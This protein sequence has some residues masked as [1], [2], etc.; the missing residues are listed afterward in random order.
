MVRLISQLPDLDIG[1][2]VV[3]KWS[4]LPVL[5][6]QWNEGVLN[7]GADVPLTKRVNGIRFTAK[8]SL[9]GIPGCDFITSSESDF[10]NAFEKSSDSAEGVLRSLGESVLL[11]REWVVVAGIAIYQCKLQTDLPNQELWIG[12]KEFSR[13]RWAFWK[14]R[15][16]LIA[17]QQKLSRAI[18]DAATEIEIKMEEVEMLEYA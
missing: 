16:K 3:V 11:V 13:Q 1:N 17:G 9:L 6:W 10:L 15:T 7:W 2:E 5:S 12:K 4:E 8:L 18:R 14:E